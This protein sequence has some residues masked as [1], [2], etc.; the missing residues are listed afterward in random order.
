MLRFTSVNFHSH[1]WEQLQ[2]TRLHKPDR[3]LHV[4]IRLIA[5]FN[6]SAYGNTL[7]R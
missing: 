2:R 3:L 6:M 1:S 5:E 4:S 7:T